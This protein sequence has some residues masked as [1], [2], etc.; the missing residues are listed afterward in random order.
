MQ[1]EVS[2]WH[3]DD[4]VKLS[5]LEGVGDLIDGDGGAVVGLEDGGV[6]LV[7]FADLD[8]AFGELAVAEE[9]DEAFRPGDGVDHGHFGGGG[10]GA[11]NGEDGVF[12]LE[13]VLEAFVDLGEEVF[14]L[15]GAVVEDGLGHLEEDFFGDAGW[16]GGEETHL[17]HGGSG[18]ECEGSECLEAKQ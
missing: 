16:A 13:D 12:G 6:P 4:G 15:L 10:A 11:G 5:L 17:V 18:G 9:E 2:E 7:A 8:P 1:A 14:V 3:E